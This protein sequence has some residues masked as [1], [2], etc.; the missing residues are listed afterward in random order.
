MKDKNNV[1]ICGVDD[2]VRIWNVLDLRNRDLVECKKNYTKII[3]ALNFLIGMEDDINCLQENQCGV[4]HL[5]LLYLE[6]S[7][8]VTSE[9][10]SGHSSKRRGERRMQKENL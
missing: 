2:S 8:D 10:R 3:V 9:E 5:D 6:K 7:K 4:G 1:C